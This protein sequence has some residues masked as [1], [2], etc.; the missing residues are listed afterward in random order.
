MNSSIL[1]TGISGFV[2]KSLISK[3]DLS[4][5]KKIFLLIPEENIPDQFKELPDNA[6]IIRGDLS[7]PGIVEMIPEK[8]D[9]LLHMAAI[10][11]KDKK[12]Q[13]EKVNYE[14]FRD[15]VES[16]KGKGLKK[17]LFI[18]TIAVKFRKRKRYFYSYS[19]EKAENFLK[20]S[21]L[22]FTIVR[23]T[24][25]LGPG[26]PVFKGFSMFAEL[27]V[28]PL[29]GGGKAIIQP[30]HLNDICN[31]VKYILGNSVFRNEVYDLGGPDKLSIKEFFKR[32]S[33]KKGKKARFLPVPMW[34]PVS[35]ISVLERVLYNVL[36]LTLGQL[37]TFRNDSIADKNTLMTELSSGFSEIDE[38]I[39]ESVEGEMIGHQLEKNLKECR[40]FTKYL[41]GKKPTEYNEK[42][43][44]E[45]LSKTN[46]RPLNG[47]DKIL[48][49][50]AVKSSLLTKFCDAYSR[51][52]FPN[53]TLR[54]KLGTLFAILET[55]PVTYKYIDDIGEKN[56][57]TIFILLGFRGAWFVFHLFI[58]IFFF[59]PLQILTGRNKPISK[60]GEELG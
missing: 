42:K 50:L 35:I 54:N 44:I 38:M 5:F 39:E 11:G 13:Y 47:F 19:K 28:I 23:P 7:D 24:M 3:L 1:I 45:F 48:S 12:S 34:I 46:I 51:F 16:G 36:P 30:V 60:E 57:F 40:V 32:I 52:F 41:I 2:G 22:E 14:L 37:A 33:E 8:F 18:S 53:S 15:L 6:V 17:V 59:L 10:T 29:F 31:S 27:P 21:G 9:T 25:I 55:S 58:S 26:S 20:S 43:Y 4:K 49:G 56:I